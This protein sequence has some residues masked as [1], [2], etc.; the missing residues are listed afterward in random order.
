[1]SKRKE[2][3]QFKQLNWSAIFVL[4]MCEIN[5]RTLPS[6]F[7]NS[8]LNFEGEVILIFENYR[9]EDK[10]SFESYINYLK[11]NRNYSGFG[12]E[13]NEFIMYFRIPDRNIVDYNHFLKG[14]YSKFS[15]NFKKLLESYYGNETRKEDHEVYEYDVIYPKQLKRKQIADWLGVDIELIIEVLDPP[16]VNK[17]EYKSINQLIKQSINKEYDNKQQNSI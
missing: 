17:E 14:K 12:Q 16:D 1:M 4:P 3:E 7:I 11:L 13:N 10:N 5:H 15:T 6:N 2:I 9:E 8:Y